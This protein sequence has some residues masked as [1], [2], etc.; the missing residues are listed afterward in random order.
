MGWYGIEQF[1]EFVHRRRWQFAKSMAFIPHWY[2]VREWEDTPEGNETFDNAVLFIRET[3]Y[4][5]AFGRKS[6]RYLDFNGFKYW[7]MGNPVN[8]TTVINRAELKHKSQKTL[9]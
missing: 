8:E 5:E 7:T 4:D 3:G 6:Y 9:L 1:A 2:T